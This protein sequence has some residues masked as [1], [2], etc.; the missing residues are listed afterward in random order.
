MDNQ[1]PVKEGRFLCVE[2]TGAT[3]HIIVISS[4]HG[5]KICRLLH[6]GGHDCI[7]KCLVVGDFLVMKVLNLIHGIS[8]HLPCIKLS[9]SNNCVYFFLIDITIIVIINMRLVDI[10]CHHRVLKEPPMINSRKRQR[11]NQEV[12][13]E[14]SY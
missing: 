12:D 8:S 10:I 1:E 9:Q 4:R 14:H 5:E 11:D 7:A 3:I 2:T 13:E 6:E